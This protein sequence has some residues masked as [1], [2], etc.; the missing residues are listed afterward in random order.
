MSDPPRDPSYHDAV[1]RILAAL[2]KLE[3]VGDAHADHDENYDY[4]ADTVETAVN[5]LLAADAPRETPPPARAVERE[6]AAPKT[7]TRIKIIVTW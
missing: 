5:A 2:R 1:R 6:T 4:I 3:P 7:P